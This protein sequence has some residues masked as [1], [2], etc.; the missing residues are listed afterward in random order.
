MHLS[1]STFG[2]R[3][4]SSCHWKKCKYT[5]ANNR[6]IIFDGF[7]KLVWENT[8]CFYLSGWNT[9]G[10][11]K[12]LNVWKKRV[13]GR[14]RK[15]RVVR[16]TRWSGLDDGKRVKSSCKNWMCDRLCVRRT[17]YY[18]MYYYNTAVYQI[19]KTTRA[20]GERST[21]YV[22]LSYASVDGRLYCTINERLYKYTDV[23]SSWNTT[24]S[25]WD[26]ALLPEVSKILLRELVIRGDRF[27]IDWTTPSTESWRLSHLSKIS[28]GSFVARRRREETAAA[29]YTYVFTLFVRRDV[30]VPFCTRGVIGVV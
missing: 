8:K 20:R 6:Q 19:S 29:V 12:P 18:V 16:C 9:L 23:K 26:C 14:C 22:I 15:P 3:C 1:V 30:G 24:P 21:R 25:M 11:S 17:R 28:I 2:E 5:K 7:I 13:L 27:E 10:K 4:A